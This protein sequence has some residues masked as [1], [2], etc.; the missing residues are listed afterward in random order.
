MAAVNLGEKLVLWSENKNIMMGHENERENGNDEIGVGVCIGF[1]S[2]V[3]V[4]ATADP[5]IHSKSK[6]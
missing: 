3:G 5:W 1:E 6:L 2:R 4:H